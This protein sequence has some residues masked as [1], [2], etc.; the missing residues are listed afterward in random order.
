M[1]IKFKDVRGYVVTDYNTGEMLSVVVVNGDKS[2][3]KTFH[4]YKREGT[5]YF[6]I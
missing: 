1:L 6:K 3:F 2:T 4:S 5:K